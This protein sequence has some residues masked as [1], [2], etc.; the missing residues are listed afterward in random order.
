MPR[1]ST[2]E[3]DFLVLRKTDYSETSLIIAGVTPDQGQLHFLGRGARRL[4]GKSFPVADLF[5]VLRLIYRPGKS[6]LYTWQNAEVVRDFSSLATDI[7]AYNAACWLAGFTLRNTAG[8]HPMPGFY[9][10]LLLALERL[11]KAAAHHGEVEKYTMLIPV[12]CVL[13]VYLDE[14]GLLPDYRDKPDQ[15]KRR[16][17]LLAAGE[18]KGEIPR[19]SSLTWKKLF[20]WQKRIL[21]WNEC[22]LPPTGLL[23]HEREGRP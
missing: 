6:D 9:G 13:M 15:R 21:E 17:A 22:A 11:Q 18:G 8:D 14:N 4:G 12:A 10:A 7:N 23:L 20:N 2:T 16:D 5:R 1:N 19:V 3:T